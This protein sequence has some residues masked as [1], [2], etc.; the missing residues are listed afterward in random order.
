MIINI[1]LIYF[2][3]IYLIGG[4]IQKYMIGGLFSM[5]QTNDSLLLIIYSIFSNHVLLLYLR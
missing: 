3:Q 2:L 1:K 4:F 5:D